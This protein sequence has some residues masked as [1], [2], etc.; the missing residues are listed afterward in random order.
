MVELLC[1]TPIPCTLL[2]RLGALGLNEVVTLVDIIFRFYVV[3]PLFSS[4][5][6]A[7]ECI[8]KIL[9]S[10]H[11][12]D[13]VHKRLHVG[14]HVKV[15]PV[16]RWHVAE[17]TNPILYQLVPGIARIWVK[18]LCES[19]SSEVVGGFEDL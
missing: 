2:R 18:P 4:H 1:H 5:V 16:D 6:G 8:V 10:M 11:P 13:Q 15:T 12:L 3:G 7:S 19:K 17:R 9:H 14:F